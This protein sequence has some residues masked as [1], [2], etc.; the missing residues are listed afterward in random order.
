MDSNK[1]CFIISHR[2]FRGNY[3]SY[4]KYYI[5]NIKLFYPDSKILVVDNNSLYKED[6]F[7]TLEK[8]SNLI[9][10]DN[11]IESKFEIGA[12]TVAL[13]YILKNNFTEDYKYFIFTQD[14]FILKNK[15]DFNN[16]STNGVTACP[17]NSYYQDGGAEDVA[18][19][20]LQTLGLYDR[21]SE[22]TFCWCSSFIVEGSKLE[23]LYGY[24]KQIKIINRWQS[25]ASERYLA[26]IL[27]ELNNFKN[28]DIDG[29]I[30]HL[31]YDCWKVDLFGP[32][33]TFFAK[34]VQQKNETTR[35][36]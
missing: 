31:S 17:I 8:N 16:L 36:A 2:W 30:R 27:Y 12:Y 33:K 24:F 21:L 6:I 29:D 18:R 23:Q 26:R 9:I 22:L 35:D 25:C 11:C 15:Y 28:F 3:I 7:D 14:N 34:R 10:L 1:I 4:L 13:D 5:E 32:V 19:N 20:V